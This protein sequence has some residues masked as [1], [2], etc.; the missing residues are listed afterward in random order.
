MGRHE[1]ARDVCI[2]ATQVDPKYAPAWHL[3][4][5]LLS[6]QLKFQE[7]ES[8]FRRAVE[9]N[10]GNGK[11]LTELGFIILFQ[12]GTDET[13]FHR[14]I[15]EAETAFR[16]SIDLLP[17]N[18]RTWNGLAAVLTE[19]GEYDEAQSIFQESLRYDPNDSSAR[20]GLAIIEKLRQSNNP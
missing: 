9:L 4:G 1:P 12:K 5:V 18:R 19:K 7:A 20:S 3:Q 8:S 16:K 2:R 15:E 6:E 13:R 11:Y 14:R 17:D 10:P